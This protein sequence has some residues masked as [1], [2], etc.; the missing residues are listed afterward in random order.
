MQILEEVASSL[1]AK[2]PDLAPDRID[3]TIA[4]MVECFP[5][6]MV[7]GFEDLIPSMRNQEHD[8]HVL[9]AA[10]R[11]GAG[12][13]VTNNKSHFQPSACAPYS[14]EVQSADEFLCDLWHTDED[15]MRL[16]LMLQASA[17][18]RSTATVMQLLKTLRRTAPRF[19]EMALS[20][21]ADP[22]D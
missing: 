21:L 17:L 4:L 18:S 16:V 15:K 20:S 13:I 9:A 2:R 10:V 1:K 8:R 7:A 19:A 11:A 6:A 22:A 14:I 3:R 5:D 12:L